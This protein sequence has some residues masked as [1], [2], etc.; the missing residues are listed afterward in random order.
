M[1][2]ISL[3]LQIVYGI[4]G[5]GVCVG[6]GEYG[7]SRA[8][9]ARVWAAFYLAV[10]QCLGRVLLLRFETTLAFILVEDIRHKLRTPR[11]HVWIAST[12]PCR[13]R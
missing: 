13:K 7:G 11:C 1:K 6:G 8:V 2:Y 5:S 9:I 4:V 10:F 12:P 3:L